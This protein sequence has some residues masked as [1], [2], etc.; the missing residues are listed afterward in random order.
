MNDE[1]LMIAGEASGDLH[2][3][4]VMKQL[5]EIAPDVAVYG[6][7]G[8]RMRTEGMQIVYHINEL[9][10]M[11]FSDVLKNLAVIR[12]VEKTL[13]KLIELK[14]PGLIV[15][16]DFPGMNLRIAE[17]AH[18]LRIPVIYYIAPQVWAWGKG[19]TKKIKKY[20]DEMLVILPFEEKLFTDAG[21]R[22][23]FVGHPLLDLIHTT[24]DR[25][26]F[27]RSNGLDAG[28]KILAL[29]PG[30]RP[31][32]V[33]KHLS[34]M[35]RAALR[36]QEMFGLQ[37]VIG[38][39]QNLSTEFVRS[40]LPEEAGGFALIQGATYNLMKHAEIAFVKSGTTT[41]EAACFQT[42]MVVV[43]RTSAINFF[44]GRLIVRLNHFSLVNI[45]GDEEVVRE[46]SQKQ[47][48]VPRLIEEARILLE[49]SVVRN[50]MKERLSDI[51]SML[52]Q[53]GAARRVAERITEYLG[54]GQAA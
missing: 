27:C 49:D 24:S 32:E 29:F 52:G 38:V 46:L 13:R 42:P 30:S 23:E 20:V 22:A 51:T 48:N 50:R 1:I 4:N 44:I 43:Y 26:P 17:Y 3:A 47:V 39:S 12:S 31:G 10:I 11:G 54:R 25:E 16:I 36:I 14:K 18:G 53:P 6:I 37:P 2:G 28:R 15:L 21:I 34:I 19:R 8:D 45:L 33:A 5:K 35:A 40:H 9:S 7:G 41:L